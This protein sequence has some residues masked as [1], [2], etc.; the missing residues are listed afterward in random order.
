MEEAQIRDYE[1]R[2][3]NLEKL[4][5]ENHKRSRKR[6]KDTSLDRRSKFFAKKKK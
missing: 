3:R 2:I 1:K 6:R 4:V 5:Q